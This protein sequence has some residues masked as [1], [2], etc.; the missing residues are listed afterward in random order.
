MKT[1]WFVRREYGK[2]VDWIAWTARAECERSF[3]DPN[4]GKD[5]SLKDAIER[6]SNIWYFLEENPVYTGEV[7]RGR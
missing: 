2:P 1:Y 5:E 6:Y 7:K 3:F 4:T